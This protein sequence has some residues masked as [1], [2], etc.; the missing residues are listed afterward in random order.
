M[1]CIHF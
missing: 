1:Y